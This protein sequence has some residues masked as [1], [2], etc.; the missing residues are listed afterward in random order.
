MPFGGIPGRTIGQVESL[1]FPY[2]NAISGC[3]YNFTNG[4]QCIPANTLVPFQS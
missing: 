4:A 3:A 1:V 2:N